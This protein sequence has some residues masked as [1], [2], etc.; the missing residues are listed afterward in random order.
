MPGSAAA[1]IVPKLRHAWGGPDFKTMLKQELE[2]LGVDELPL[3]QGLTSGSHALDDDIEVMIFNVSES[4]G[5]ILARAGIFYKSMIAGCSCA[6]DPTPVDEVTEY[7]EVTIEIDE[8]SAAMVI[9][10]LPA[11]P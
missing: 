6:D 10:L 8:N 5:V 2:K 11:Q 9:T 4:E 7:C 3:Q 1:M